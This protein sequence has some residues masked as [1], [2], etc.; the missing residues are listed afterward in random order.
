MHGELR[1]AVLC[2]VLVDERGGWTGVAEPVHELFDV[3]GDEPPPGARTDPQQPLSGGSHAARGQESVELGPLE[4]HVP[5]ALVEGD[6]G[7]ALRRRFG[8]VAGRD[9][10]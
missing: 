1:V 10:L 3:R 4:T 5:S 6:P 8:Q 7:P 2:R 9:Q